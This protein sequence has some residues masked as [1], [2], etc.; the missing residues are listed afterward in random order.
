M[1]YKMSQVF[2]FWISQKLSTGLNFIQHENKNKQLS[3]KGEMV[4]L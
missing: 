3:T 4:T 2:T 1:V